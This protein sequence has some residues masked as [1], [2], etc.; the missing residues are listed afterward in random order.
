[1][2]MFV[3]IAVIVVVLLAGGFA[4]YKMYNKQQTA[5]MTET[6]SPVGSTPVTSAAMVPTVT[7]APT[8]SLPA[9][10]NTNSA[11]DSDTAD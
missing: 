10:G 8:A 9:N 1:M 3:T 6:Q 7:P 5:M 4:A 2:K 11:L